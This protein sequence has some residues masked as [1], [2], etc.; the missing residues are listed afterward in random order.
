MTS[1]YSS[2]FASHLTAHPTTV[3]VTKTLII[4]LLIPLT[5]KHTKK[6][7]HSRSASFSCFSFFFFFLHGCGWKFYFGD[8]SSARSAV[9]KVNLNREIQNLNWMY[10][11]A[12]REKIQRQQTF[13]TGAFSLALH[14]SRFSLF[15]L[16]PLSLPLSSFLSCNFDCDLDTTKATLDR[17]KC[18]NV[19]I[20]QEIRHNFSSLQVAKK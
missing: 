7:L 6:A 12:L 14:L 4:N 11:K 15:N 8:G 16:L 1:I 13:F 18:A 9:K 2:S 20:Q 10:R 19:S 5:A 3:L 17:R